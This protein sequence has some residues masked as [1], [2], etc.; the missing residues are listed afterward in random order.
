MAVADNAAASHG[1]QAKAPSCPYHPEQ[2][3]SLTHF[4]YMCAEV[5][6]PAQAY[7][8]LSWQQ[9]TSNPVNARWVTKEWAH[10]FFRLH[11]HV[12]LSS[13]KAFLPPSSPKH[14][15]RLL[16][17]PDAPY[18]PSSCDLTASFI[19]HLG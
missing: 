14:H 10:R 16:Q 7:L 11:P 15:Y 9:W 19:L 5:A 6:A 17:A 12:C 2:P 4:A 18:V 3:D 13:I 1:D 8:V